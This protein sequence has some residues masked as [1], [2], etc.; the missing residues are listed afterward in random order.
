M[1][2]LYTILAKRPDVRP[3]A[4]PPYRGMD[5]PRYLSDPST[6]QSLALTATNLDGTPGVAAGKALAS[7]AAQLNQAG[8]PRWE[9]LAIV[10]S[11]DPAT[12]E[13][14]K[15][16][17]PSSQFLGWDVGESAPRFWSAIAH[18]ADFLLP[19][20]SRTWTDRLNQNGL[21][22]E[23]QDAQSFLQLYLDSD[24]PDR[25]YADL[26]AQEIAML[27][28]PRGI[29]LVP[30]L[31]HSTVPEELPIG[32]IVA[33]RF[34]ILER[35]H[36]ILERGRFRGVDLSYGNSVV[37]TTSLR[38][39]EPLAAIKAS[40]KLSSPGISR[41]V[42]VD[43]IALGDPVR[44]HIDWMVEEEPPYPSSLDWP[45]LLPSQAIAVAATISGIAANVHLQGNTL[46]GIRPATIYGDPAHRPLP[47]VWLMPRVERFWAKAPLPSAGMLPPFP[48]LYQGPET[49]SGQDP[50]APSDV[51]SICVV[52]AEWLTGAHPFAAPTAIQHIGRLATGAPTLDH[53][54]PALARLLAD[55]LSKTPER[56]PSAQELAAFLNQAGQ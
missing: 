47:V 10:D 5:R 32:H 40:L 44:V 48:T 54:P 43:S 9:V 20:T 27:Y 31:G 3:G 24:D 19:E 38:H 8:D 1:S 13:A 41:L 18:R 35:L 39:A 4:E 26:D 37:L 52:L 15:S 7:V 29:W 12:T 16:M 33:S 17:V 6:P 50:C 55:G 22:D 46:G 36:G 28:R 21:F 11:T 30:D 42:E 23:F 56:R 14:P 51:F 25:D 34:L 2:T 45:P 49:L 53:I